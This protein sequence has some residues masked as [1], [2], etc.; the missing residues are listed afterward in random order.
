MKKHTVYLINGFGGPN[1]C[2]GLATKVYEDAGYHVHILK[3]VQF[4]TCKPHILC[5]SV[6]TEIENNGMND[7]SIVGFSYGGIIG[8]M[9]LQRIIR[10]KLPPPASV[11]TISSPIAAPTLLGS[12]FGYYDSIDL[13]QLAKFPKSIVHNI[14]SEEDGLVHHDLARLD[15]A[16]IHK[17]KFERKSVLNH[18]LGYI[19]KVHQYIVDHI[20]P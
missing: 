13:K 9:V 20:L 14:I 10:N 15:N 19:P 11:I 5:D 18:I 12:L 1:W 7:Y 8:M 6:F 3:T 2:F 17:C 16:H 4:N